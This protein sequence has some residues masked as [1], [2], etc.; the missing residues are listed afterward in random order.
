MYF[1]Y[2]LRSRKN[3]RLY[4]GFTTD[5]NKRLAE[6]NAGHTK[7]VRYVR[8]LDLL[9][10]E[11][12]ASRLDAYRRERYLKSGVGREELKGILAQKTLA[13]A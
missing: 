4:T 13:G 1:V 7:S 11:S 10:Y 8:P 12:Y 3:S 9:Y 5:L 2:V 6:H